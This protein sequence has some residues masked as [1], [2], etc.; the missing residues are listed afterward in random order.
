MKG[1]FVMSLDY[2]IHWGVFDKKSIKDYYE[3]IS[4]VS[5]VIDRLLELSNRYD[6][7]LTFSTVSLLFVKNKEDLILHS[8]KQ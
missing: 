6:V 2:E 5:F 7:K 1:Y 3:N 4:N 8:L